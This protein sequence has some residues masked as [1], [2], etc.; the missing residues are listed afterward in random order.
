MNP[1]PRAVRATLADLPAIQKLLR[2]TWKDTYSDHLSQQTLDE[3]YQKW[4]SVEFL[5]KQITNPKLY[6][7]L[8]KRSE[9]LTGLATAHM[10]EGI[11]QLFRLYVYPQFQRQG[12][13]QQ[14]LDDVIVHFPTAKSIQVY[15]EELNPNA[16]NFYFKNG[17]Q[18]IG[19]EDEKIVTQVVKQIL[20]EKK[21]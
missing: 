12:V 15:V 19:R 7:T 13:G 21:L 3:V 8:I 1:N 10:T 17:F 16:Q 4:Q 9:K 6:F 2:E 20:M 11:I 5:S 18:E 14:L